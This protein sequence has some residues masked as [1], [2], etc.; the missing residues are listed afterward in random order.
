MSLAG[1]QTQREPV[2]H[3]GDSCNK[4][5]GHEVGGGSAWISEKGKW[6]NE[7]LSV[8][9]WEVWKALWFWMVDSHP[10]HW[11]SL[12]KMETR[13]SAHQN[14]VTVAHKK[15]RHLFGAH[16][17]TFDL[18]CQEETTPGQRLVSLLGPWELLLETNKLE[19]RH[20]NSLLWVWLLISDDLIN[21]RCLQK[22]CAWTS[23]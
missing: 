6:H 14:L 5:E 7:H 18:I 1:S 9:H 10:L 22:T 17:L 21:P 19:F 2:Q 4:C 3:L 11:K 12:K 13:P 20:A 23:I 15:I 8:R 16:R